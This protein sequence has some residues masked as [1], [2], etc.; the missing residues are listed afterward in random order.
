MKFHYMMLS[1]LVS[2]CEY[3]S[4]NPHPKHLWAGSV[5]GQ[6]TEMKRLWNELPLNKKPEWL[7]ME[8]ILEWENKLK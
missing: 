7:S 3:Y 4:R 8:D 6:I 5:S 1:R 2:D